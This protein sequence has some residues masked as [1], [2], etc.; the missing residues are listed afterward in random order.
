MVPFILWGRLFGHNSGA[1]TGSIS[2]VSAE[3]SKAVGCS[4]FVCLQRPPRGGNVKCKMENL[5]GM[6][7]QSEN[8]RFIGSMIRSVSLP[9]QAFGASTGGRW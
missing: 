3:K 1:P 6:F 8:S 9:Y 2:K 4:R 7:A 5:G